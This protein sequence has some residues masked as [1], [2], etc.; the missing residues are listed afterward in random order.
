MA[1]MLEQVILVDDADQETGATEKLEAHRLGLLHR[2]FSIMVWDGSGRMLLQKRAIA[3]YHSGGLWTNACCGH[4]RPGESPANAAVRR[5]NEELGFSCSIEPIGLFRY[6]SE[7]GG[8]LTEH[9]LVHIYRGT[10]DG[11]IHPDPAECDGYSWMPPED[12]R[13]GVVQSPQ[14]Y[15]AWFAKYV[16]AGWPVTLNAA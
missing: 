15:T 11:P 13:I 14:R 7:V 9:E 5:L 16:A 4:P 12:F 10:Y 3:K 8:G 1:D 6:R 2:A